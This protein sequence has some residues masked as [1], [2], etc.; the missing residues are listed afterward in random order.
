MITSS[1]RTY[2]RC[3]PGGRAG[4]ALNLRVKIKSTA[5]NQ[6]RVYL[7]KHITTVMQLSLQKMKMSALLVWKVCMHIT[8]SKYTGH[9]LVYE[10]FLAARLH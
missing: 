3:G 4:A 9:V 1:Q 5:P 7:Q 8:L 6:L 10:H 2:R